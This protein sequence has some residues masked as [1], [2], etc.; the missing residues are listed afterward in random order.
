MA[1]VRLLLLCLGRE[2]IFQ[3]YQETCLNAWHDQCRGFSKHVIISSICT[4]S[5]HLVGE[6]K[7]CEH[8]AWLHELQLLFGMSIRQSMAGEFFLWS[9]LAGLGVCEC[10]GAKNLKYG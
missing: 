2:G 9:E 4:R 7:E 10:S 1:K 6:R 8:R 3:W 5:I